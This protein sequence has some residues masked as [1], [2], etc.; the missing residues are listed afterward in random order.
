MRFFLETTKWD[1]PIPNHLYVL[2]D[3][4]SKTIAYRPAGS[5]EFVIFKKPFALDVQGRKFIEI[6]DIANLH[7]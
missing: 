3:M 4:K 7:A 5:A 2:D 1:Q 6:K